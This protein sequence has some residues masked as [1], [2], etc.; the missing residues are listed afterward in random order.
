MLTKE[1]NEALTKVGPGTPMGELLRRYWVPVAITAE[2][3]AWPTKKVRIYG[4]DLAVWK[5]PDG[6]YGMMQEKCPHRHASLAYGICEPDGLRCPYHG[7]KF[8]FDGQCIEQPAEPEKSQFKNRIKV[9]AYPVQELGGLLWGYLGPD[10]VPELPRWD[11]LVEDGVRDI[12]YADIPSNYIQIMENSVDPHHVEW[13]HGYYFEFLGNTAGFEAPKAFQRKHVR[14]AF[15]EFEYGIIKRRLLEGQEETADDWAVGH[16]LVF[17]YIMRVGGGGIDQ[18]QIRVP[19]D[20]TTSRFM[21]YT[22]HHP[23][24]VTE[25]P[26]QKPEEIPHYEMEWMDENGNYVVDYI[27]GQDIMAFA[28]QGAVTD[29]TQEHIGK[30]DIGVV[31]LRR[32]YR[33]NMNLVAEGKDPI[34]IVR[35]PHDIIELPCEKDKFGAGSDFALAWIDQG[36]SRYSPQK[37]ALR[38]LHVR[39]EESRATAGA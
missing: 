15:D 31:M 1:Q 22:L 38:E 27:E 32:M 4:E 5:G 35:E 30:S 11:V 37:E 17:P 12:G 16:P 21:L 33:E 39:A 26:E 24:G 20:D 13:M 36:F 29:R 3:E 23:E 28:T 25:Y 7:W 9:K 34:G 6:K 19:F 18:L 14:V 2:L 8:D 10:P